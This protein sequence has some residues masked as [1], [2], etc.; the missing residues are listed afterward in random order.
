VLVGIVTQH[1]AWL[2]DLV[3]HDAFD[4]ELK[5]G[6]TVCGSEVK[7]PDVSEGATKK[8]GRRDG[9]SYRRFDKHPFHRRSAVRSFQSVALTPH[10][11]EDPS[12]RGAPMLRTE[13]SLQRTA[14]YYQA[15]Q[16][17]HHTT[18]VLVRLRWSIEPT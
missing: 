2:T 15:S 7:H 10:S 3:A 13:T 11:R 18:S 16:P 4:R 5:M 8:T 12:D 17:D 9:A 14:R 6:G 1:S